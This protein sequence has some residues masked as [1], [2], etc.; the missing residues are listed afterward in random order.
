MKNIDQELENLYNLENGVSK[1]K[2]TDIKKS[3]YVDK[4][5]AME[6]I[7]NEYKK[8]IKKLD[9]FGKKVEKYSVFRLN[10]IGPVLADL[11]TLYNGEVY[12]Y[13]HDWS[14]GNNYNFFLVSS[15]NKRKKVNLKTVYF[16]SCFLSFPESVDI[17]FYEY[18]DYE[19]T[20]YKDNLLK[21]YPYLK[22]FVDFIVKYR[23]DNKLKSITFNQLKKCLHDFVILHKE[24]IE[25]V[26]KSVNEEQKGEYG[27][28]L[29]LV[30]AKPYLDRK[31]EYSE[32]FK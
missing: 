10:G 19:E 16:S 4:E 27:A 24:E 1:R 17:N 8:R 26:Q 15:T 12:E 28:T 20:L 29:Q 13:G 2:V 7:A 6:R 22:Q 30:L 25:E 14:Y 23:L 3:I 11:F 5:K 9:E 21:Y 31:A 18:D 32:T